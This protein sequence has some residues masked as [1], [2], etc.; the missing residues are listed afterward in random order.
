MRECD[1]VV[2]G[3]G[4]VGL[5]T[6]VALAREGRRVV[7]L[8]RHA[9]AGDEATSQYGGIVR[10]GIEHGVRSKKA[11][12]AARGR[13]LLKERAKREGLAYSAVGE[14]VLALDDEALP[15]LE[16]RAVRGRTLGAGAVTLLEGRATRE[17]E[18]TLLDRPALFVEDVALVRAK[19]LVRSL[20]N[21]AY[22]REAALYLGTTALADVGTATRFAIETD[23]DGVH[24]PTCRAPV[25]VVTAGRESLS[26]GETLGAS[27]D[28]ATF[29]TERVRHDWL[30]LDEKL[31]K[32]VGSLVTP[33]SG[34]RRSAVPLAR[35]LEGFLLAGPIEAPSST[36]ATDVDAIEVAL[37]SYVDLPSPA[38]PVSLGTSTTDRLLSTEGLRARGDAD[39]TEA[40]FVLAD[41]TH[42]GREGLI[43]AL[44]IDEP[45]FA[46]SLALGEALAELASFRVD[47]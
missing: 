45:G 43:V 4:V 36:T 23:V 47:R 39:D 44:G 33:M 3:A 11:R 41:E 15:T 19:E 29:V 21:E 32:V 24:G 40:D 42:H 8:E 5:S 25:V 38:R 9:R 37:A 1:V 26:L 17:R 35:D 18:P 30:A 6:A 46:A 2:I 7:V 13:R 28:L 16:A 22:D 27:F 14:L 31:R 12:L 20:V 34:A 10:V